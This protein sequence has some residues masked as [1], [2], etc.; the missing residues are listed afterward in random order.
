MPARSVIC[1]ELGRRCRFQSANPPCEYGID[2][3][4]SKSFPLV[5]SITVLAI[6]LRS[7]HSRAAP[8]NRVLPRLGTPQSYL[9]QQ[10]NFH[11]LYQ[12]H[13]ALGAQFTLHPERAFGKALTFAGHLGYSADVERLSSGHCVCSTIEKT[14]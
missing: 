2:L 1:D 14:K 5:S 8:C 10:L 11:P 6:P 7:S 12:S 3:P 4:W 13:G 9:S